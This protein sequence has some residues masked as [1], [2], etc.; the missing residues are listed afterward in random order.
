MS[1]KCHTLH[2]SRQQIAVGKV[3]ERE[4]IRTPESGIGLNGS[5]SVTADQTPLAN[6]RIDPP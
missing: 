3:A 1:E 5:F 4:S 6:P 2:R